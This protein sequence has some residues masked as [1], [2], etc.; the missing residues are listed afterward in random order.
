[1]VLQQE[2]RYLL[3][4]V[5]AIINQK[6]APILSSSQISWRSM[7]QLAETNQVA[8]LLYVSVLGAGADIDK[9]AREQFFESY[10][11]ELKN[12]PVYESAQEALIGQLEKNRIPSMILD[13]TS[14][15]D[16][17]PHKE[18]RKMGRIRVWVQKKEISRIDG[19]M[20]SLNYEPCEN[21]EDE[22]LLYYK[23]PGVYV[24]VYDKVRFVNKKLERFFD[25]P[26]WMF[27]KAEGR[28]H[29]RR[30]DKEEAYIYM[31]GKSANE[32]ALGRMGVRSVLDFWLYEKKYGEDLSW[33]HIEKILKKYKLLEFSE[34]LLEL[35][36]IWFG[37]GVSEQMDIYNAMET[38]IFSKG[39]KGR[40]LS[41]KILP[42]IKDVADFYKRDRKSEWLVKKKEWMFP[43]REYME[44]L[45]PVLKKLPFLY[46]AYLLIRWWRV[47]ISMGKQS[48][49]RNLEKGKE[50]LHQ[51]KSQLSSLRGGQKN[52]IRME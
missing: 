38:Y 27:P 36:D 33:P 48:W 52:N 39:E 21:R 31:V 45:F 11:K 29:L 35:G 1:M 18:M 50:K 6:K 34:H 9:T 10:Q 15:R 23:I 26:L 25:S 32:Y 17:Y 8:S 22:G 5:A 49:K 44:T 14:L 3:M 40:E 24:A 42:L 30:L 7:Y 2:R 19:I 28:R 12:V 4:M 46:P 43:P 37:N 13:G 47:G 20:R 16:L 41:G 51:I